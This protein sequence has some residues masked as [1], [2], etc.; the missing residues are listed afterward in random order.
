VIGGTASSSSSS[1]TGS[2]S[3]PFV[4]AAHPEIERV[5]D[6]AAPDRSSSG[7]PADRHDA[8]TQPHGPPIPRSAPCPTGRVLEPV[9]LERRAA[10]GGASPIRARGGRC[11]QALWF[12]N[13]RAWPY[14]VRMHEM[15]TDHRCTRR[16]S[17]WRSNLSTMLF[18]K[19]WPSWPS[20]RDGLTWRR[21]QTPVL[22]VPLR[23]VAP[24]P[25]S[26]QRG[27]ARWGPQN[28]RSH[29]WSRSAPPPRGLPPGR[30]GSSSPTRRIRRSGRC[31]V[32]HDGRP[33]H[34]PA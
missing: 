10:Q 8:P 21:I 12:V 6:P 30:D 29:P 4:T 14:F 19:Q 2:R 24:G 26:G 18:P 28:R 16:S 11:D 9:L 15:T 31:V 20:W 22:P 17:S 13:E 33:L 32:R 27:G 5:R 1:R 34:G 3:R 23:R 7:L 25:C